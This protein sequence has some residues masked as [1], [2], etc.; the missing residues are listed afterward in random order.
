MTLTRFTRNLTRVVAIGLAGMALAGTPPGTSRMAPTPAAETGAVL[1]QYCVTCHNG[2]L[3]TANLA[4]GSL[5]PEKIQQ[6]PAA[7]EKVVRKLRTGTMPP[8]G[9]PRP[10]LEVY[11]ATASWLESQLDRTAQ[12]NPGRPALRKL[13]RAEYTETRF[14]ICWTFKSMSKPCSFRTTRRLAST[15]RPGNR[16]DECGVSN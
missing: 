10:A 1:T 12:P 2:R 9:S 4:I 8:A 14:A 5:N 16:V 7:W 11:D 13:N 15:R 6:N 3:M